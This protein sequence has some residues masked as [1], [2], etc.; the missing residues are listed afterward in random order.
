MS[1]GA[2]SEQIVPLTRE[3]LPVRGVTCLHLK[4]VQDFIRGHLAVGNF[5]EGE[6][7]F[8]P[9]RYFITYGIP[10]VAGVRGRHAHRECHQFL[11]CVSGSCVVRVD[12][13]T[14]QHTITLNAPSLGLYVPPMIWAEEFEHSHDSCLLVFASHA[15]DAEDYIRDYGDFLRAV[16][17]A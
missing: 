4:F 1:T 11:V 6:I 9:K 17:V 7:P 10:A 5:D 3:E 15:Y 2:S 16:G 14:R 13:G 12:D 8:V